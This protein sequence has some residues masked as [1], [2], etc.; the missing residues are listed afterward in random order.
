MSLTYSFHA[1]NMQILE[2]K[3][4]LQEK[5]GIDIKQIRLI[6]SGKQLYVLSI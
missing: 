1:I 2:I 6:H 3:T 5:E 4:Q